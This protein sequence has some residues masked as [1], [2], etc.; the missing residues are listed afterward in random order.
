M[1]FRSESYLKITYDI[2]HVLENPE[3]DAGIYEAVQELPQVIA[4]QWLSKILK[5]RLTSP[6]GKRY[7][8]I[9]GQYSMHWGIDIGA[10]GGTPIYATVDGFVM[11]NAYDKNGYGNYLCILAVDGTKHYYA[12]MKSTAIPKKGEIVYAGM[13][14]GYVGTTGASTGNHLHYEIRKMDNTRIAPDEY[15]FNASINLKVENT[16]A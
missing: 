12:H 4:T 15:Q 16:E 9:T 11:T 1:L 2:G 3:F 7:H 14:I 10:N 8:P 5:G 6:Y 13:K